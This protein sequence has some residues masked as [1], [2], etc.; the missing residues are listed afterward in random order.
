MARGKLIAALAGLCALGMNLGTAQAATVDYNFIGT[1]TGTLNGNAFSGLF[2]VNILANTS[3]ISFDGANH[4]TNA[5]F[6]TFTSSAGFAT[7]TNGGGYTPEVVLINGPTGS[8]ANVGFGQ[9]QPA[10]VFFVNEALFNSAF[11]N[12]NLAT[13]FALTGG[14]VSFGPQTYLTNLGNLTFASITSLS[15]VATGGVA[16][17]PLPASWTMMLGG[18]IF[19]GG[20]M[21]YQ[22][23][24]RDGRVPMN[25]AA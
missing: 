15:F 10:P 16:A 4:Y 12:Y 3:T 5:G 21:L 8:A 13:A 22:R 25:A 6:A 2:D 18:L 14:T 20:F 19:G 9:A 11:Q 23:R 7:F 17:T 24:K 1:G